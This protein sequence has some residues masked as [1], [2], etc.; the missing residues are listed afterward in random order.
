MPG[1]LYLQIYGRISD[2]NLSSP[3]VAG[4]RRWPKGQLSP[5]AASIIPIQSAIT[6]WG[7]PVGLGLPHPAGRCLPGG[8]AFSSPGCW[9]CRDMVGFL[10]R[11]WE[12]IRP[13]CGG[14][15][16]LAREKTFAAR[17]LHRPQLIS[18]HPVGLGFLHS[19]GRYRPGG[20]AFFSL[21][22][23]SCRDM[24]V[25]ICDPGMGTYPPR[26]RQD[27]GVGPGGNF[28]RALPP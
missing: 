4:H 16:A 8:S 12:I 18:N 11:G 10:M 22:C 20:S 25:R 1:L 6:Q 9:I 14:T 21:G 19:A 17:W 7:Y 2:K 3:G 13:G 27:L 5:R 15:S 23:S 28:R 26:V 24:Y